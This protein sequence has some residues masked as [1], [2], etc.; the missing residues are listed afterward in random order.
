MITETLLVLANL[1]TPPPPVFQGATVSADATLDAAG[2]HYTYAVTNPASNNLD[3]RDLEIVLGNAFPAS[4]GGGPQPCDFDQYDG[5]LLVTW[6]GCEDTFRPGQTTSGLT[7]QS[8]RPPAVVD[9][10][11]RGDVWIGYIDL[12]PYGEDMSE[13]ETDALEAATTL[14]IPTIGP[15]PA[16]PGSFAHWDRWAAD[17]TRA[18][19]LGWLSD[20][21]LLSA[22]QA[23]VAAARQ[24][25]LANDTGTARTKLQAV[26]DA[27]QA[28]QPS[29]RTSEGYALALLNAQYLRNHLPIPCEPKL[30][31]APESATQPLGSSYTATAT[32]VNAAAGTP[33]AGFPVTITVLSGPHAGTNV[34]AGVDANGTLKLTYTGTKVGVDQIQARTPQ[35]PSSPVSQGVTTSTCLPLAL[36]SNVVTVT[37]QGGPD[38]AVTTFTPPMLKSAAGN[39][40]VVY[41]TTANQGNL[42]AGPSVTRYYLSP[43]WPV[44]PAT[45]VVVGERQV[46]A[47]D[48]GQASSV[49][50]LQ[51]TVPAGVQPGLYYLA[52]CADADHGV[53][54]TNETNNCTTTNLAATMGVAPAERVNLPPDCSQA[55]AEPNGLWP[56]NHKLVQIQI[57]GVTDPDGDPVTITVTGITQ[58]EPTNGV[59]D[60]D[61]SPDGFGVG[62]NQ[63]QL[64]AERAGNGNGRV[65]VISF[66]AEDG[67]GGTCTGSAKVTVPH[68][69]GKGQAVDDG[70]SYDS[71][72]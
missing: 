24:A 6:I 48:A 67:K 44:E 47:L 26:I 8:T 21:A 1:A 3:V 43:T 37:W 31:L 23:N 14:H 70:Q 66:R 40:F 41:E 51:L 2:Y 45:A 42:P 15:T 33:F 49:E 20:A 38:L 65:Y 7:L 52:A 68:D 19:Q 46:P 53:N 11:V 56:P 61:T 17:L 9:G 13:Q 22:I 32:L 18:G 57:L 50:A 58:D 72:K 12:K 59:G 36:A 4:G 5:S 25:I 29:Q 30:S 16:Q 71:T 60:G 69:K 55:S 28:S 63:P 27:I 62:T 10:V 54:E 34:G 64:R 35:G 39:P